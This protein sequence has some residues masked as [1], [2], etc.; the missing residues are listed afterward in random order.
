VFVAPRTDLLFANLAELK[1]PYVAGAAAIRETGCRQIGTSLDSRDPE[2][3]L[4]YLLGAPSDSLR[5]ESVR[6]LE[7]LEPLRDPEFEPCA[8]FCTNCGDRQLFGELPLQAS[9]DHIRVYSQ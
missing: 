2:Y 6:P 3:A 8:V 5:I 9:F 7:S 1:E 4:W